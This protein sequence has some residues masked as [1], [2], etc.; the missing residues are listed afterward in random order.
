MT[1]QRR[2]TLYLFGIVLGVGVSYWFYGDR[3]TGGAWLPENKVRQRLQSTLVQADARG[4]EQMAAW[5][6]D[7]AALRAAMPTAEV[8]FKTSE[9]TPDSI[10]YRLRSMVGGRPAHLVVS[11]LRNP[12]RDSTATLRLIVAEQP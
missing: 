5:P 10:H 1:F 4:A 6:T 7:L 11:V 2:V 3:L 8:D 9:R 12:D